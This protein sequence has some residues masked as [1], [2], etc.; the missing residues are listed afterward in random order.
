MRDVVQPAIDIGALIVPG[1][2][3]RVDRQIELV[4]RLFGKG[5]L[6]LLLHDP[7]VLIDER[8]Q[9]IDRELGV[10][11]DPCLGLGPA[12]GLLKEL[13]VH[14]EHHV[15]KHL[16]ESAIGVIGEPGV[17]GFDDE[18]LH[19]PAVEPQVQDRVHHAGHRDGRP[20]ADRNQQR[21]LRIPELFSRDP[22]QPREPL[23]ELGLHSGWPPLL[24]IVEL[25]AHLSGDGEPRRHRHAEIRHLGQVGPLPPEQ[26]FHRGATV[27]LPAA[28]PIDIPSPGRG[29]FR[30]ETFRTGRAAF[31]FHGG[32]RSLHAVSSCCSSVSLERSAI[33]SVYN[34]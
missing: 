22:F 16:D 8:F 25:P 17:V 20:G 2:E 21:V 11:A 10:R 13:M 3:D 31:R 19:D 28:E 15:A 6:G 18:P 30:G 32:P 26:R 23:P 24:Q 27:R 34:V 29:R 12:Q 33:R 1:G 14:L 9:R 5:P 4:H 7:L